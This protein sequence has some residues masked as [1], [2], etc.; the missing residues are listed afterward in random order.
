MS[1]YLKFHRI[2]FTWFH[3]SL[4]CTYFLLHL[5]SPF[6]GWALPNMLLF[7][8]RTF[9]SSLLNSDKAV[10]GAKV[11]NDNDNINDNINVMVSTLVMK[12]SN[13]ILKLILENIFNL[14]LTLTLKLKLKIIYL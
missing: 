5:S 7:G 13:S 12:I 1:I 14:L 2:E 3:Y 4:T 6:N 9:L 11:S 10:C 8:V